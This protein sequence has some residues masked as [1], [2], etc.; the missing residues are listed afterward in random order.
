MGRVH[1]GIGWLLTS[2]VLGLAWFRLLNHNFLSFRCAQVILHVSSERG[3]GVKV[4]R[5]I[6]MQGTKL[7]K[8]GVLLVRVGVD[9]RL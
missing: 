2:S 1:V 6:G 4:H 9:G 3:G 8:Y 7:K 5:C